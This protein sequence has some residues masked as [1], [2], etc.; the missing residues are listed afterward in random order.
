MPCEPQKHES[1][2]A[3]TRRK[4]ALV[5]L[6]LLAFQAPLRAESEARLKAVLLFKLAA[7]MDWPASAF[8]SPKAPLVIGVIDRD[9]V[10]DE[11]RSFVGETAN[12]RTIEVRRVS[13]SD[14]SELRD[15]HILFIPGIG[16]PDAV[17]E[18]VSGH[19]VLV[20]GES[21][22]FLRRG[23]AI[24]LVKEGDAI[25]Y[26]VNIKAAERAGLPLNAR[27]IRSAREGRR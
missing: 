25:R 15:C 8:S 16:R 9:P 3:M 17:L 12:K 6:S 18:A 27:I 11:L 7:V 24:A 23:G 4:F 14:P 10:G 13:A 22:G 5:W 1:V 21:E 19:P 26:D 20:V 2:R